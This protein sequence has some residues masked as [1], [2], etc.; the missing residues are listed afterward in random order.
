MFYMKD[1]Q[2]AKFELK[3]F[4]VNLRYQKSRLLIF[5]KVKKL[6][7][8]MDLESFRRHFFK[9]FIDRNRGSRF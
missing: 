9:F 2:N 7:Q 4:L 8:M 6:I 5:L 3:I 1:R